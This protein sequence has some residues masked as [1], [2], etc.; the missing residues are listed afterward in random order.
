MPIISVGIIAFNPEGEYRFLMICRKHTLGFMDFMRGKYSLYNKEYIM[1]LL[2]V[3]TN[4]EK[5]SILEN[6]FQTLWK[7]LWCDSSSYYKQ[8]ETASS[9]KFDE[10]KSG[11]MTTDP[12]CL[13]EMIE[14]S[15]K[16][17]SWEEAEWGFPKG[18][19]NYNENDMDCALREFSEETGYD[20]NRLKNI[21]NIQP[22]EEIFMGSNHKLYKHKYYLMQMNLEGNDS[23]N[24]LYDK[25]EV[26]KVEW[27]TYDEVI[28][29]IRPYNLEKKEFFKKIYMC[30]NKYKLITL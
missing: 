28:S 6:D 9:K 30:L 7:Q 4:H 25:N 21:E 3:M 22:Y 18:R 17:T 12:Y 14:E 5:R 26:S 2:N 20:K 16:T 8:E 10:L 23:Y 24:K 13:K 11:I 15:F 29:C 1:G 27:K 19:R